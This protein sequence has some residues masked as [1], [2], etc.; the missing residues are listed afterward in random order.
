MFSDVKIM[1][2]ENT[3]G[4]QSQNSYGVDADFCAYL[5]KKINFATNLAFT[6]AN[7][8]DIQTNNSV[9]AKA[10]FSYQPLQ[11]SNID[12]NFFQYYNSAFVR[13]RDFSQA[14]LSAGILF[15]PS[16]ALKIGALCQ[17]NDIYP[18]GVFIWHPCEVVSCFLEYNQGILVPVWTDLY[19]G[20]SKFILP[21]DN[22]L[23]PKTT[24][25][26]KEKI[27]YYLSKDI[28][29]DVGIY[30]E[31]WE[32]YITWT[33]SNSTNFIT[34]INVDH[35]Y[36][37][38]CSAELKY[39]TKTFLST[40]NISQNLRY[41]LPFIPRYKTS[42][43]GEYYIGLLTL[44]GSCDYVSKQKT[45]QNENYELPEY[46]SISAGV[47]TEF[48]KGMSAFVKANNIFSALIE[49]QRG[50]I[51]KEPFVQAGVSVGF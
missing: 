35:A 47:K 14:Q 28:C 4:T 40:F 9:F 11:N 36:I 8:K 41:D 22:I 19:V 10:G 27:S 25:S 7:I 2:D 13:N 5:G 50:F 3:F 18:N 24:C 34:P 49:S 15:A 29:A 12:L 20:S 6:N 1:A 33:S 39:K 44:L 31:N 42:V 48:I 21:Y 30:Q 46:V 32:N 51:T 23:F 37:S 43:C 38:G 45:S 17:K 26:L 16:I